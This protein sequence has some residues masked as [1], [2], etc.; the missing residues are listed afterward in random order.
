MGVIQRVSVGSD[1]PDFV[2]QLVHPVGG[3]NAV[4]FSDLYT[5]RPVLLA[6]ALD[7]G[8][9]VRSAFRDLVPLA[10]R[11]RVRVLGVAI[12]E[13]TY[14]VTLGAHVPGVPVVADA[15]GRV[16][17]AYGVQYPVGTAPRRRRALFLVDT[18]GTVRYSA[19]ADGPLDTGTTAAAQALDRAVDD[20][21]PAAT[22]AG[23]D[24]ADS[25]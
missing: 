8:V 24:V 4:R 11:G 17:G 22:A 9:A 6:F 10:Q 2:S 25:A 3:R 13:P 5:E 19:H 21:F 7:R 1:A 14:T 16:A 18:T 12:T 23:A 20:L 15:H